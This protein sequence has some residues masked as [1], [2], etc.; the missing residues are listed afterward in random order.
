MFPKLAPARNG[1]WPK[2]TNG[3]ECAEAHRGNRVYPSLAARL[4]YYLLLTMTPST[5]YTVLSG[6]SCTSP[7]NFYSSLV[8]WQPKL[9]F[10]SLLSLL[11]ASLSL[12]CT[13]LPAAVPPQPDHHCCQ[14]CSLQSVI[15]SADSN[16]KTELSM[17][18]FHT[19]HI[20]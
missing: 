12:P 14:L 15:A 16:C 11:S 3:K 18:L 10:A 9:D 1:F 8:S 4:E 19:T 7:C 6:R 5:I 17:L 2:Y 20:T 13:F